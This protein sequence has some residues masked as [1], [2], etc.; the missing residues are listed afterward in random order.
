MVEKP[1]IQTLL[2]VRFIRT[3]ALTVC[4]TVE[5]VKF[6]QNRVFMVEIPQIQ[7][8]L[9]VRFIRTTVLT[10]CHTAENARSIKIEC[11]WSKNLKFKHLC[12]FD[13]YERVL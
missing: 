7:T 8:F 2:C 11:L 9:C 6:H 5:N 10:V 3:S 12:V 13:S 1:Q 4:H